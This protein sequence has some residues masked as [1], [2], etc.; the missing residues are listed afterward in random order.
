MKKNL[1]LLLFL[2]GIY[3]AS[4]SDKKSIHV[5]TDRSDAHLLDLTSKFEKE[6]GVEVNLTFVKNG[7]IEKVKSYDYD[8]IISKDS[9]ELVAAKDEGLL[10]TIDDS[11]LDNIPT[12]FKDIDKQWFN[13]SYRIR[14]FHMKK[15]LTD[16]PTSYEDLAKPQYKNRICIRSLTHNYNLEMYGTMLSYMGE[17]K[18]TNWFKGFKSNIVKDSAAGNDRTQVKGVYDGECDIAVANSYYRGLMLQDPEQKKW[19][20]ATYLYIPN[21]ENGRGA[22]ALYSAVGS[23]SDN[24]NNKTFLNYLISKETQQQLSYDN[25]EYPIKTENTSPTVKQYG[26][27]QKL[28]YKSIKLFDN[29]QNDLF[30][31]RKKAYL[32]IKAN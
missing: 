20:E 2:F 3:N 17:E 23:L 8:A 25:Y 18:F 31:L 24:T 30:E 9:S 16:A 12:N 11:V 28:D 29:V 15:G 14:S 26:D 21:Q 13:M 10:H 19:A 1:W 7:I 4:A 32:I 5:I 27:A 6:S 22:I